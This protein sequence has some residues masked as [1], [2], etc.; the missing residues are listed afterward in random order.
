MFQLSGHFSEVPCCEKFLHPGPKREVI[1]FASSHTE[2]SLPAEIINSIRLPTFFK[3]G[4]KR[5]L[6]TH[7][8]CLKKRWKDKTGL[9]RKE[10]CLFLPF[11]HV[12]CLKRNNECVTKED[13][14]K[15]MTRQRLSHVICFNNGCFPLSK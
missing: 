15:H 3:G 6:I 10:N 2:T 12:S 1:R 5:M 7:N 13:D 14:Y 9:D 4:K 11:W 8:L